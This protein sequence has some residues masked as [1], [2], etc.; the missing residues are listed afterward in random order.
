MLDVNGVPASLECAIALMLAVAA[1]FIARGLAELFEKR[2]RARTA[3][4]LSALGSKL[5]SNTHR[6]RPT[7]ER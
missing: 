3:T 6:A 4:I 7:R 2:A 5:G 1:P